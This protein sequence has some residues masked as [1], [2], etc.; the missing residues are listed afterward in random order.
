MGLTNT[1]A[2]LLFLCLMMAGGA[3]GASR[4]RER[5]EARWAMELPDAQARSADV[6]GGRRVSS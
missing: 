2:R 3:I 6:R 1:P 5:F 4:F